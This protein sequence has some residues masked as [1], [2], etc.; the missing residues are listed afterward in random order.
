MEIFADYHTHTRYSHG[1]GSIEDNI[2]AGIKKNLEEIAIS[3]HGPANLGIGVKPIFFKKMRT[4]INNLQKKYDKIKIKLGVEANIISVDGK[5]DVSVKDLRDLDIV[6]AGLHVMVKPASLQDGYNLLLKN[7][8]GKIYTPMARKARNINT[9]ALV[10]AIYKYPIDI[11]AHP[12]LR[13]SIDTRELAKAAA[14]TGTALEINSSHGY[15]TVDFA[16]TAA[17]EGVDFAIGSDAH[18]PEDVGNLQSGIRV[19]EKAGIP[20]ERV[21][22]AREYSKR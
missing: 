7:Q 17:K 2:K 12:G 3:D 8:L 4:E 19:A 10:E 16:R 11:I 20:A 1:K 21:I 13:L 22:N 14:K 15:L 5:L 9:K 18:S 6:L